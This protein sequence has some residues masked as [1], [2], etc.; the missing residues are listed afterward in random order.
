MATNTEKLAHIS[1]GSKLTVNGKPA[2]RTSGGTYTIVGQQGLGEQVFSAD[3]TIDYAGQGITEV[4]EETG[5]YTETVQAPVS[6]ASTPAPVA[7]TPAPAKAAAQT[8]A[9]TPVNAPP[10][11]GLKGLEQKIENAAKK[12]ETK[13]ETTAKTVV[14]DVKKEVKETVADVK[15]V[16]GEIYD[17]AAEELDAAEA[18]IKNEAEKEEASAGSPPSSN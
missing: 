12:I 18:A 5:V 16:A 13:V 9:A 10:A 17:K 1:I 14:A 2:T 8:P 15:E 4:P 7:S 11:T 3:D 6:V